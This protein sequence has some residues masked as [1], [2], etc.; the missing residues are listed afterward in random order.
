MSG[1][2]EPKF[3]RIVAILALLGLQTLIPTAWERQSFLSDFLRLPPRGRVAEWKKGARSG[4]FTYIGPWRDKTEGLIAFGT[5]AVS[6]LSAIIRQ[7]KIFYQIHA[8]DVLCDMDRFV[9]ASETIIPTIGGTIRS[10]DSSID[11]FVNPCIK[12]DGRRIG[13]EGYETVRWAMDQASNRDL[14]EWARRCSG[15]AREEIDQLPLNQKLEEWKRLAKA[16]A[17]GTNFWR[18]NPYYRFQQLSMSLVEKDGFAAVAP[19][20]DILRRERNGYVREEAIHLLRNIDSHAARL[21][22][23]PAGREAIEAIR[24]AFEKGSLKPVYASD[25]ARKGAYE[26][27]FH[28]QFF[29]DRWLNHSSSDLHIIAL[30][31]EQFYGEP[32]VVRTRATRQ[33]RQ[34]RA[35]EEL[36]K[37]VTFMTDVDPSFPSWEYSYAGYQPVQILHPAFKKKM[38]RYY[39][40]WKKFKGGKSG[41]CVEGTS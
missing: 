6:E 23:S 26:S 31:F 28:S 1:I 3:R 10:E 25:R 41:K 14:A 18:L 36:L 7:D 4:A 19:L 13:K 39:E 12:V 20:T 15:I 16:T 17:G 9:P 22:S 30:A 40:E 27:E 33:I 35:C 29:N 38:A 2:A 5:D 8:L 37:F 21:R 32:L 34:E 11:G 24:T